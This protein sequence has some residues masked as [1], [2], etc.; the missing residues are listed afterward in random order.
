MVRPTE[1]R[2]IAMSWPAKK[3]T[4]NLVRR[5]QQLVTSVNSRSA[6]QSDAYK[7][8]LADDPAVSVQ[9]GWKAIETHRSRE[10]QPASPR[11]GSDRLAQVLQMLPKV[12]S[13]FLGFHLMA[14]LG[15]GA[16]GKVYL[17]Q[18]GDLAGRYVALKVSA[19]I[20][21]ESQTLAQLQH[22][23]VMPI[24]S[25]HRVSPFLAVCMPY[26]GST[27]L[28]DIVDGLVN[29]DAL[30]ESGKDLVALLSD[31][32]TAA[33][34]AHLAP[35]LAETQTVYKPAESHAEPVR[36][37]K[38]A[39]ARGLAGSRRILAMLER[40]GYV[41][42]VLWLVSRVADGLAHAHERGILH[43][44]LKP[45]N[46]LITDEGQPMLL[47]FNLARDT[48][49]LPHRGGALVG[50]TLA[51]MSP[52]SLVAFRREK[53]VVD[54]RSDLY[55]LGVIV[56]E[57]LTGRS[58]FPDR[59]G[60]LKNV[61][62]PMI[63]D[64]S[65]R[66]PR[67]RCWNKAVTPAVESI[68]RHC[69]EPNPATRYQTAQELVEDLQCQLHDQP[70]RHAAEPSLIEQGRKW[71][72]RHPRLVSA[73]TVAAPGAVLSLM[74]MGLGGLGPTPAPA[75]EPSQQSS[76]QNDDWQKLITLLRQALSH[77]TEDAA[78]QP[79]SQELRAS[80]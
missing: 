22:T 39:A 79:P 68:I 71:L 74:L 69:L 11:K 36:V 25:I 66:P 16:S 33:G 9:L 19:D 29:R 5:L 73:I 46:I 43:L 20:F 58:A 28:A 18:Q 65:R 8:R 13:K 76:S 52:E 44:D 80:R 54:A 14:E 62:R 63:E 4:T 64:R 72:R 12:G 2:G 31:R 3:A 45:A 67:L 26:F 15:K 50:G 10:G 24:Y 27:T 7:Q 60:T 40:L 77:Q 56:Y 30:P 70:L 48:K 42:A 21:D 38:P 32:R 35:W 57:L 37:E 1:L 55:S 6:A 49:C 61:L 59:R 17:A 53:A 41:Q 75:V 23:N 51:Y 47:D 34:T 78:K